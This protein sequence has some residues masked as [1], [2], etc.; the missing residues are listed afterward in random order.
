MTSLEVDVNGKSVLKKKGNFQT[1]AAFFSSKT[2]SRCFHLMLSL[3]HH[4]E[5]DLLNV[6]ASLRAIM[7]SLFFSFCAHW[8]TRLNSELQ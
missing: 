6:N 2:F 4:F 1:Q 7:E 5:I 3:Y 8:V